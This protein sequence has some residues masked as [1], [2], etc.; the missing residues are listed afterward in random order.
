LKILYFSFV[1]LDIPNA[2]QSHTLGVLRGFGQYGCQV[3]ALVPRPLKVKPKMPAVC[4]H[5]LWPWRFSKTGRAWVKLLSIFI[6]FILCLRNKYDAIYVREMEANPGPRFCSKVF[7]TPLYIEINDLIIPVLTENGVRPSLVKKV[8][9][10][11]ESDFKQS[12]GL[13]IPSFPMCNWIIDQYKLPESKVHLIIN[14]T[15]V[16]GTKNVRPFQAKRKLGIPQDCFCLGFVG[17]IYDRYDFDTIL[18]GIVECQNQIPELYFVIVGEGPLTSK[19]REKVGKLGIENRTIFT[20][21]VQ[22]DELDEILPAFDIGLLCLTKKNALRYGP[23]TTKLS[24]YAMYSLPI[25]TAGFSLKGY[26]EDLIRG[27]YLVPPENPSAIA[28]KIFHIY[29]NPKERSEK[30][31]ILYDYSTKK[32]TWNSVTKEILE[33]IRYD[34]KL[35]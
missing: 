27:L 23:I 26:P 24:T 7:R 5:Y 3:D 12:S 21:Y 2:C 29:N 30:A 28:Y 17:N 34:T 11:Q 10:H 1:E 19:V 35:E 9:R 33:I 32:L 4:F 18:K 13:I 15:D 8:R 16:I 6:M 22:H 31:K 20:G 25:V 14:G